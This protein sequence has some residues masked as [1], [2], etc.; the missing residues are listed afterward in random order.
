MSQPFP[1]PRP[2]LGGLPCGECHI[3]PGEICDICGV[4][5]PGWEHTHPN[6]WFFQ[7]Q[8]GWANITSHHGS[9]VLA[10]VQSHQD[11]CHTGSF[12]TVARAKAWALGKLAEG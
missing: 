12:D 2:N 5:G 1:Q 6:V 4:R 10:F 7:D 11:V 8:K 9:F 3:H